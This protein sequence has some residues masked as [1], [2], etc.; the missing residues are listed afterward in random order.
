MEAALIAF[1]IIFGVVEILGG[2]SVFVVAKSAI[3]EIL[4][5]LAMGFAVMTF[6]LAALLSEFKLVRELLEKSKS[7]PPLTN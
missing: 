1:L 5:T 7:P 4:G 3:H 6:G 2:F